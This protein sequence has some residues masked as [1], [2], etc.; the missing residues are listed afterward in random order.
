MRK[1]GKCIGDS[2]KGGRKLLRMGEPTGPQAAL[3]EAKCYKNTT[4]SMR[5]QGECIGDPVKGGRKLRWA[6][7][8]MSAFLLKLTA[9]APVN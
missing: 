8:W 4:S 3:P 5:K 6:N 9:P 2:V 1:Q 7:D